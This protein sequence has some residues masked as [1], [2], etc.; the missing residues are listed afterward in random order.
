MHPHL[1]YVERAIN[2]L[3]QGRMIILTD[4]PDREDE[5]DMIFPAE[6]ITK[7]I[8]NFMIRNGSGIIC[9]SL[10]EA[11]IRKLGL[12][13]MVDP[14]ENTSSRHTPFTVSIEAKEGVTTGVSA[15]DRARTILAASNSN[16]TYEDIVKPGHIFP[17]H[18]RSGG[19]LE[20][21]GHTE[22]SIDIV[23]LAGFQEAAVLCEI[24][25]P[26]GTMARGKELMQFAK[27]HRIKMLSID[28]LLAY[29]CYHENLIEEEVKTHL[30]MRDYD[31]LIMFVVKE[32]FSTKEHIVLTKKSKAHNDR[33]L[34]RVH[35]SCI[36]GDL[37][38]SKRCD[39]KMQFE[40]SLQK[41]NQE[42]G[43]LI[44]LDQEG[45]G[46]GL[47]NKIKA[48]ALQENGFDTVEANQHLGLPIDSRE[49]YI[50]ANILRNHGIK[51]IKLLT[52]N[53]HKIS[54]LKKYG[55]DVERE[56]LPNFSNVHNQKYLQ[57]K[58]QK[59]NHCIEG[60]L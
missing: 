3:R 46:I 17:L 6:I 33:P 41:I 19:V 48:Y 9:L 1:K 58:K 44:Y 34:V 27:K 25:N 55:I 39:C 28:E 59:L 47:L 12:N 29:R 57:T 30:P 56:V 7:D 24:M 2:E 54:N 49:Y 16:A 14:S 26:D 45:R 13:Y 20:R 32:K 22:G 18:A 38:G 40:F 4:H 10:K 43:A 23:R 50:A 5:G 11:Q 36:T 37:L 8:V 52:N 53:P 31:D 15:I 60:I 21:Q 35:S 51:K 42:G